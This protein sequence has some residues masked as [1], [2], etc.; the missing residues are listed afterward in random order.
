[1][2]DVSARKVRGLTAKIADEV[3]FIRSWAE[4][5]LTT[6]AV[7]PSGPDLAKKMAGFVEAGRSGD[8]LELGPG[9][10]VV[11]KAILDRGIAQERLVAVEFNRD[12]CDLLGRRFPGMSVVEGDAYRLRDTLSDV[13][14][15]SLASIV[16]SLPLFTRP[17]EERRSLLGD[18]LDL[19][20]PGAPFI[21]FSYALVPPIAEEEGN[22]MIERT[23]WIV[24]NLPPARVF[25]YRRA[26][27]PN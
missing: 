20:Q 14:P 25:V 8:V 5:P 19:L 17:R 21:Q 22:L 18:A 12:F 3:R 6:G 27:Q 23:N 24:M 1:M 2:L 7:S 26:G 13:E 11:T 9:T 10:G 16:S 15:G 4:K